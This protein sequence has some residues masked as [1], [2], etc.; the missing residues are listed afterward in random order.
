[1]TTEPI[2]KSVRFHASPEK[3]FDAFTVKGDLESW[4]AGTATVDAAAGGSWRYTFPPT[5]AAAGHFLTVNRPH[6]LVWTWEESIMDDTLDAQPAPEFEMP[7]VT[8]RYTFEPDGDG[9]WMHI[10]ESGHGTDE[11]RAMNEQGINGM[12]TPLR[13]WVEDGIG[14]DWSAT[15]E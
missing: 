9:T 4:F 1:M 8:I 14:I 7:V 5:M 10:E 11:V 13:A 3:L 2:T 6:E 15:P 12:I